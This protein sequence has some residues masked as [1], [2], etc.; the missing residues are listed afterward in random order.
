MDDI[1]MAPF[2]YSRLDIKGASTR[3]RL[4]STVVAL[5]NRDGGVDV[6]YMHAGALKRVRAKHVV[7]AAYNMMLPYV[8]TDVPQPQRAAL[9]AGVKA[10][11]V[12][13][14][15]AVR[16]WRP[17]IEAGVHEVTNTRGF[18]SRLKLDYP[19][20]L[21]DYRFGRSP[22]DPIVLHLV[23][24]PVSDDA[25]DQRAAWRAGRKSLQETSFAQFE[26]RAYDELGRILG[27]S[28]QPKRDVTAIAVYRWAHGYAY[29][30]N[31]LFDK[32]TDPP[33]ETVARQPVGRITVANSDAAMSAYAHAAID[34]AARAVAEI[35]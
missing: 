6:G 34:E 26:S 16:Q 8:A 18:Y 21:G 30:F 19:V 31:S 25:T 5:A 13:V 12:Y 27:R 10:P 20:S 24:V 15:L 28:F 3:L 35:D 1:V 11:L 4:D 2:D 7:Y 29:G 22:Q 14:K 32:E 17:W 33:A 9:A 23:H